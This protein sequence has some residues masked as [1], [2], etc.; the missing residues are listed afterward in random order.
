MTVSSGNS[1]FIIHHSSFFEMPK[2]QPITR[3]RTCRV[4]A[5]QFEYPVKGSAATR[6]HCEECVN[7]DADLRLIFER[8]ST[9][10]QKIE[11]ALKRLESKPSP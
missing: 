2:P 6:F 4:C 3:I 8:L 9:R 7:I 5:K 11:L 1:S 10:L